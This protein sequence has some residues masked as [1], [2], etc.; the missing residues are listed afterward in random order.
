MK[1]KVRIALFASGSGTNAENITRYFADDPLIEVA[2][3]ICN[4]EGAGVF[5]R[6]QNL[7]IPAILIP[8]KVLEDEKAMLDLLKKWEIDRIVLAGFLLKIPK[9][10]T[11]A[12]KNSIVN[13]HPALLPRYGGKG[14]YGDHV[15]KALLQAGDLESGIT[16]H[17]VNEH[18]DDGKIIAQYQCPVFKTDTLET[19]AHRIH[20]LEYEYY[21]L[22]IKNWIET[23][24]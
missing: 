5:E 6:A 3:I 2:C 18:Y 1:K 12:Y 14:M 23:H 8:K 15:H 9:Y 21:P 4:K 7:D 24:S 13:I 17:L 16:I 11:R 20:Q 22:V 10:L 19:L